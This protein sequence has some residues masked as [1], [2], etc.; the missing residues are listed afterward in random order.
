M[1]ETI[2]EKIE[3]I[4]RFRLSPQPTTEIY[5]IRWRGK[6]YGIIKMAYHHK[7]WEGR[8]RVHKFAVSSSNLDFRL[9]YDTENL[10][11]VLE[12]VSDG[13]S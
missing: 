11:W 10:F 3:V 2:Q 13:F 6:E 1:I 7:V 8:T 5:K 9:T 12:E 4:V